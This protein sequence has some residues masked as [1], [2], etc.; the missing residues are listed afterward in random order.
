MTD[1]W[2]DVPSGPFANEADVE[3]RL[4]LPLLHA[5]GYEDSD[6]HPKY[7]VVFQEGRRGRK[8]E[9]DFVVFY[10]PLH[11]KDQSLIVVEA[12]EPNEPLTNGKAQGE[13]YAF[14]IRAPLLLL[15]NGTNLEIW[16]LQV[17]K[18]S[19]C[20]VRIS[21]ALL[22][23]Q[24][25]K[26]DSCLGK[27]AAY[28]YCRSLDGKTISHASADFGLYETAELKRTL[29]YQAAVKRTLRIAGSTSEDEP[30]ESDSL[31]SSFPSGAIILAPSG[32]GKTILSIALLR[33]AIEVRWV[34]SPARSSGQYEGCPTSSCTS[35][36]LIK[37]RSSYSAS[38]TARLIAKPTASLRLHPRRVLS[39]V[40]CLSKWI[41][42]YPSYDTVV[43]PGLY[44]LRDL[45]KPAEST[46]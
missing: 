9:A 18:E 29:K 36:T 40:R 46:G 41:A 32:Y 19:E 3:I 43:F 24:R 31:L 23:T 20:I 33:A 44:F 17:T 2:N 21:V 30:I 25:G 35:F 10:G 11:N 13:S 28:A 4:V 8:P 38:F 14:N 34:S 26:I 45:S 15:I 12:K 22:L 42:Q 37:T 27:Q 16:Q 5:L 39:T 6:I 1:F 7:P